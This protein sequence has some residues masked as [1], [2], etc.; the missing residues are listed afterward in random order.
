M[1]R[2]PTK[3]YSNPDLTSSDMVTMRKRKQPDC[4]CDITSFSM[5]FKKAMSDLRADFV[6]SLTQINE[7]INNVIKKDL[8]NLSLVTSEI[9]T[10]IDTLRVENSTLKQ[11]VANLDTKCNRMTQDLTNLRESVQFQAQQSESIESKVHNMEATL[12]KSPVDTDY[13]RS[14]ENKIDSLEQQA[15][16]N[17]IEISNL[18]ER[19]NEN[20]LTLIESIGSHIKHPISKIDILSIHRVPH[21]QVSSRPKNII[22]KFSS[23]MLR[24]NVLSA[25]RLS[26]GLKSEQLG[27]SGTCLNIYMNEHLTLNNKILFRQCREAAKKHNFKF[28]WIRHA[29]VLARK[30]ESSHVVAIRSANDIIKITSNQ[31]SNEQ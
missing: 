25:Y 4:A 18:P 15:R 28:V 2:S 11:H 1:Q 24:D 16:N 3:T 6:N 22:V 17:N 29:T 21:A 20:L 9:K 30:S 23:R 8:E 31:K 13:Y 12:K 14:L 26:K 7:N 10:E 19:R 27:L 5:E